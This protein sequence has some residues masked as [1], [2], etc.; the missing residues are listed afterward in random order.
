MSDRRRL[1]WFV[2]ARMIVVTLFYASTTFLYE[3]SPDSIEGV[4]L[5]GLAKLIGATYLFS[6]LSLA[7][8]RLPER[9]RPFLTYTQII[10]DLQ[11]V[12]ILILLTG[13]ISSPYS[14]LYMLAIISASVLLAR[15]QAFYAASL[16]AILYGAII[17][18]QYYGKLLPLGLTPEAA[19]QYGLPYLLNA[20]F[21]NITAFYLTALLTGYLAER[22]RESESALQEKEIDYLE[23]ERLNSSIVKNLTSGL[24][25]VTPDGRVRVFNRF[26]EELTGI[27]QQN[28]YDRRLGELI[29]GFAGLMQQS[30]PVVTGETSFRDPA[31]DDMT[32]GYRAIRFFDNTGELNGIIINFEDLTKIRQMEGE[33]KRADRLAAIGELSARIAHEIRN[34]LASISG[35]VQLMAQGDTIPEKDRKLLTIVLRE[36]DRLNAL[37]HDFLAY[38]RPVLLNRHSIPFRDIGTEI[39]A[40]LVTDPRFSNISLTVDADEGIAVMA[41]RD[42]LQQVFWNLLV[43][44]AEAMPGGG[45]I[46]VSATFVHLGGARSESKDYARIDISDTGSGMTE[47]ATKHL[48]EPFFTTKPDGTGLGLATVYRIIEAHEGRI[49]VESA[50]GRGTMF[51]I[52]LPAGKTGE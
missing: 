30:D 5:P 28:A 16:C 49:F 38:A 33:L 26:A 46:T 31:G 39:K 45:V 4:S 42:Q 27:S 19:H 24:M 36:T 20:S 44:A 37:I 6:L 8:L 48:F 50:P 21:L 47:E 18:L 15:R 41:D 11:L 13:G 35:S 34:P 43:N 29:P 22:V 32:L 3:R 25:T 7:A 23:L 14:F 9:I 51:S 1:T 12:T 2:I 52:L 40:L 17:D 10:W